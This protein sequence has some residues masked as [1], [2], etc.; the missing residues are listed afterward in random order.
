MM[1]CLP[2]DLSTRRLVLCPYNQA[3]IL[4]CIK[5]AFFDAAPTFFPTRCQGRHAFYLPPDLHTA[6]HMHVWRDSQKP[7]LAPL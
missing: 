5:T 4:I 7:P 3:P 2:G 1:L 6:T